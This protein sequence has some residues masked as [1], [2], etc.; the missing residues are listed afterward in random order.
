[1]GWPVGPEFL[2]DNFHGGRF[3]SSRYYCMDVQGANLIGTVNKCAAQGEAGLP[4]DAS[5]MRMAINLR[6]TCEF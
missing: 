6:R 3:L 2:G 1:M 5:P 4:S